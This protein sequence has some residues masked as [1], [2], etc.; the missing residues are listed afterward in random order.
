MS[1]H[2]KDPLALKSIISEFFRDVDFSVVKENNQLK[3]MQAN[4][5][6]QT[7]PF[8]CYFTLVLGHEPK[9]TWRH[10]TGG[11]FGIVDLQYEDIFRLVH[12]AWLF[13]YVSFAKAI[14][15]V[16]YAYPELIMTKGA[17]AGSLVPLRHR[18]GKYY[19]YHQ[20]SVRA[21]NVEDKLAAH[22]NY[23]HRSTVY[24][25]QLPTMPVLT[26]FGEENP[27]LT[28]SLNRL[29]LEF[30]P[31]FLA[32]FLQEA[33]VK[34]ILQYREIIASRAGKKI[35]Q[36]EPGREQ[37]PSSLAEFVVPVARESVALKNQ[38]WLGGDFRQIRLVVKGESKV[39]FLYRVDDDDRFVRHHDQ[40]GID[41]IR[42]KLVHIRISFALKGNA[43][44]AVVINS[45]FQLIALIEAD[46]D[47][48]GFRF[49]PVPH[50][51]AGV[52]VFHVPGNGLR[53][54]GLRGQVNGRAAKKK[55][56][57]NTGEE[58]HTV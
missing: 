55:K 50:G 36:R 21:A 17:S 41:I 8:A 16:A 12:P 48:G 26:T 56:Y 52:V 4:C 42:E 46:G 35:I 11:H 37:V 6:E 40:S 27:I 1:V 58:T 34:F 13:T 44:F 2:T 33:Q 10:N 22:L 14:Y 29:S 19:W 49:C 51:D 45:S 23:Y 15:E 3:Q 24:A 32:D 20:I 30:L 43:E 25:G 53:V 5:V 18:S 54:V 7:N 39:Y 38:C 57:K 31:D 9:I 47:R 28:K